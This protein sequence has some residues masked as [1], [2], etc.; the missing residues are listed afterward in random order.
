MASRI[1]LKIN[2][3]NII[4]WV[5]EITDT[6]VSIVS[7]AVH[8]PSNYEF[9]LK[10]NES[11]I[12]FKIVIHDP[13]ANVVVFHSDYLSSDFKCFTFGSNPELGMSVYNKKHKC[14]VVKTH[15]VINGAIPCFS[16]DIE[17]CKT[18]SPIC[19]QSN[20]IIGMYVEKGLCIVGSFVQALLRKGDYFSQRR[21]LGLEQYCVTNEGIIIEKFLHFQDNAIFGASVNDSL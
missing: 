3:H 2:N 4:G 11:V 9:K 7:T 10:L 1:E 17:H 14:K 21:F 13:F 19:N 8:I 20:E 6:Y 12:T 5:G 18:G 15:L 16:I